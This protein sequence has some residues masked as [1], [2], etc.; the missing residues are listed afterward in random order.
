MQCHDSTCCEM[1]HGECVK[2]VPLFQSLSETEFTVIQQAVK[3]RTYQKGDYIFREGDSAEGLYVVSE[4]TVKISKL[5]DAGKEHVIRFLFPG[6]FGGE[7]ALFHES[8]R[9]TNAE[10][11]QDTVIC[12]IHRTD[13]RLILQQNPRVTYQFLVA[14]SN[15]LREAD[16]WVSAISLLDVEKR[17]AK[18]LLLFSVNHTYHDTLELP[19]AKKEFASLLGVTPET[20]SRKLAHFESKRIISLLGKRKILIQD[21]SALETLS[22]VV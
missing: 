16:E 14:L 12:H 1:H 8:N 11:L 4:G 5:S 7:F 13:L 19:V 2:H 15:Q 17:L 20:L 18:T 22:G 21:R 6:D 9:Y 10:V 3:S